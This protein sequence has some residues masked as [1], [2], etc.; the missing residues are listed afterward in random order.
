M[1]ISNYIFIVFTLISNIGISQ[2]ISLTILDEDKLPVPNAHILIKETNQ[3]LL[4][5]T[6]GKLDVDFLGNDSITL[7]ISFVGFVKK[8]KKFQLNRIKIYT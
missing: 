4:S 1:K 3:F 5:D 2:N 7:E 8:V 6:K